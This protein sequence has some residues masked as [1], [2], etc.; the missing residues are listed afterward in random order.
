[1]I[2]TNEAGSEVNKGD[3]VEV[4]LSMGPAKVRVPNIARQPFAQAQSMLEGVGL[5][6]GNVRY[7]GQQVP[8]NQLFIIRQ[9]IP[10]DSEV[11]VNTAIPVFVG[12]AQM[13]NFNPT[14]PPAR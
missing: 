2:R 5:T 11:D 9:E 12:T 14:Q 8:E 4:I 7:S 1:M 3:S 6:I 10:A 13:N